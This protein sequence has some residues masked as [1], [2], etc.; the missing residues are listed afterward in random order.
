M[1]YTFSINEHG[2]SSKKKKLSIDFLFRKIKK[3]IKLK[4]YYMSELV[5]FQG[6]IRRFVSNHQHF[7]TKCQHIPSD[8]QDL[9][10]KTPTL[11]VKLP[12]LSD[13]S[14]TVES[15]VCAIT[16]NHQHLSVK[17]PTF[18]GKSLKVFAICREMDKR[19]SY[20]LFPDKSPTLIPQ[21]MCW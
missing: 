18:I 2:F 14:P 11:P 17:L 9:S 6:L 16:S 5:L 7:P 3:S 19:M 13:K 8:Y 21:K 20:S 1:E 4:E 10:D 12:R 15:G